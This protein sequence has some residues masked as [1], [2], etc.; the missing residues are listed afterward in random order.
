MKSIAH[1]AIFYERDNAV[2]YVTNWETR[3]KDHKINPEIILLSKRHLKEY[4]TFLAKGCNQKTIW[5]KLFGKFS[6]IKLAAVPPTSI[7]VERDTTVYLVTNWQMRRKSPTIKPEIIELSARHLQIYRDLKEKGRS[8]QFI[9]RQV[10][11]KASTVNAQS[12][13]VSVDV[14]L[15]LLNAE[16]LFSLIGTRMGRTMPSLRELPLVDLRRLCQ[17]L[18]GKANR[19]E[20]V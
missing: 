4:R 9:Y 2:Y 17:A 10:F 13:D 1:E 15:S 8:Q 16:Q 14:P 20:P 18:C 12:A 7:F 6:K 5:D 11:D 3:Q 19:N